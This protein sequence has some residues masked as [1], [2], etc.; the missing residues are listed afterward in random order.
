MWNDLLTEIKNNNRKALARAISLIEN[1]YEGYFEFLQSLKNLNTQVIGITGPPG[2]GK[3]T[4]TDAL[5][6]H[7]VL[8]NKKVAVLCI[9]PSSPFNQGALL[10][11]RI[12][13][14]AWYNDQRVFI[15]SLASRGN[16]GGVNSKIIE[17]T[18]LVQAAGFNY[19]IIETVGAG[20][21]EV[22]IAGVAD[23]TIVVLIPDSGDDIQTLK[24]GLLEIA[25]IFVVNKS[26]RS[27]AD[28]FL[29]NLL[30]TL[31]FYK[32]AI[33]VIPTVATLRKG[34]DELFAEIENKLHISSKDKRI[35]LLA[36]KAFYVLRE[37]RIKNISKEQLRNEIVLLEEKNDFNLYKF[38][39]RYL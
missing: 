30:N 10:G 14:N 22:E 19:I 13:M 31:S 9:D 38:I 7:I 20:Q 27:N 15:R 5:I 1:E 25:D 34:I 18:S 21:N 23:E 3:S 11:D 24:S 32:N 26:D 29:Q 33:P 39:A 28:I 4:L 8:Q 36:Q 12:R 6:E 37:E 17:I 35:M 16:V 2:A